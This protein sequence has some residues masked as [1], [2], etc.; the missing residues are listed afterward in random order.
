MRGPGIVTMRRAFPYAAAGARAFALLGLVLAAAESVRASPDEGRLTLPGETYDGH[1]LALKDWLVL[2]PFEAPGAKDPAETNFLSAGQADE[3]AIDADGI[4]RIIQG[5]PGRNPWGRMCL[6]EEVLDFQN[7]YHRSYGPG[8]SPGAA[9]AACTVEAVRNCRVYLMSGSSESIRVWLN[10]ALIWRDQGKHGLNTYNSSIAVDLRPGKNLLLVKVSHWS[11]QLWGLTARLE[12]TV[13]A[14]ADAALRMQRQRYGELLKRIVL[15]PGDTLE[16][17]PRGVPEG[18][19]FPTTITDSG[20]ATIARTVLGGA[21]DRWVPPATVPEGI[22]Y[23]TLS[24]LQGQYSEPFCIGTPGAVAAGLSLQGRRYLGAADPV[25]ADVTVLQQRLDALLKS[26]AAQEHGNWESKMISVLEEY[27][28]V[29]RA[30]DHG[31]EAFRGVAGLH[32]RGFRSKIDDQVESYRLFV[33]QSHGTRDGALPLAIMVPTYTEASRPFIESAFLTYQNEVEHFC[34]IG[35]EYGLAILWCGYRTEPTGNPIDFAQIDEAI[36]AVASD[37]RIDPH[38][39]TLMGIC[40]GGAVATAAAARW[41]ERFAAVGLLNPTFG[42]ERHT[43]LGLADLDR[44]PAIYGWLEHTDAT[45]EY[46]SAGRIPTYVI[47]DGGEPGHGPLES[48]EAFA[49]EAGKAGFPLKF[50]RTIQI[51]EKHYDGWDQLCGW[52]VTQSRPSPSVR[53]SD[54]YFPSAARI[55]GISAV[56][57]QRFVLVEGTGGT[58]GDR[59][60]IKRLVED[61]QSAWKRAYFVPCRVVTDNEFSAGAYADSNLVLFGNAETNSVWRLRA[62]ALQ[63]GIDKSR[64]RIGGRDWFGG[65]LMVEAAL[66]NPAAPDHPIVFIGGKDLEYS[67]LGGINLS[68]EGWFD[69]AIWDTHE[70]GTGLIAAGQW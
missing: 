53:R 40:S 28:T 5:E 22:Y 46:L 57:A 14:A 68:L 54:R 29:L 16:A 9:Y 58:D 26:G 69:Y 44:C 34:S 67:R 50:D 43:A 27:S 35:E 51:R 36:E 8:A 32:L 15:G 31:E 30:L 24:F 25:A 48:A 66:P 10:G 49:A 60:V 64:V 59:T 38:R 41:P 18:V 6:G 65:N 45:A 55:N 39:I 3:A 42:L 12:P 33:P 17:A 56:L 2:G 47:H 63:L 52:L 62:G 11:Q 70:A 61:F 21:G 4:R 1:P 7:L 37:Y 20:G 23:A 13:E 19:R